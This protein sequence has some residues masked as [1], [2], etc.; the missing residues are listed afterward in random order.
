MAL[1]GPAEVIL[2]QA[3]PVLDHGFLPLDYLGGG[4]RIFSS[5]LCV[6]PE[7]ADIIN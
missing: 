2:D 3:F 6:L 7:A 5:R 4:E 1:I